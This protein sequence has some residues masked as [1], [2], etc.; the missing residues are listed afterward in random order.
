MDNTALFSG[1][2]TDY[3][4][5][6][7]SY[8]EALIDE[9]LNRS[10]LTEDSLIA[11]IGAGTG[12]FSAQLLARGCS[13]A[14][15]EPNAD[16]RTSAKE[17][18]SSFPA[19]SFYSGDAEHTGLAD[20]SVSLITAAQAFHWFDTQKFLAESRRILK[21]NGMTA[22]IWDMR[23]ESVPQVQALKALN[24]KYCP[25]FRGFTAGVIEDDPRIAE[26]FT[27][28]YEKIK[29]ANPQY[30]DLDKFIA[31][32]LSSSY[33]P[34]REDPSC[35]AYLEEITELFDRYQQDGV[36]TMPN[37]GFAYIGRI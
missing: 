14:L 37:I 25:R 6:R 3:D 12:K 27:H 17:R 35:A 16:M 10:D 26:Y 22:L 13:V 31:R 28:G 5:A 18:L 21:E 2:A 4:N 19:A 30:F 1:K 24:Q 34:K 8:P 11:D 9:I 29:A 36:L 15:V 32:C 20:H 23:D 33:A 7:P